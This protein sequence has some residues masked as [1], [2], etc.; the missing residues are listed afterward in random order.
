MYH[1]IYEIFIF[2]T[3]LSRYLNFQY[4]DVQKLFI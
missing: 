1:V 2:D 4:F 3:F